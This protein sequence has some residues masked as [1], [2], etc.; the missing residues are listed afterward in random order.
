MKHNFS[1]KLILAS[2]L[3]LLSIHFLDASYAWVV[4]IPW[5]TKIS[6][7]SIKANTNG[8]FIGSI[9]TIWFR[10]LKTVKTI[11]EWVLILYIVYIWVQMIISMGDVK[12]LWNTKKQIRYTLV[13]LLFINIPGSIYS[14]FNKNG[15]NVWSID[16]KIFNGWFVSSTWDNNI[17]IDFFDFWYTLSNNVIAFLKVLIFWVA[18][19]MFILAW[20]NVITAR[21]REE[22]VS[23][24]KSKI[25]Y[26][27]LALLFLWIIEAWKNIA[28]GWS[29][30]EGANLFGTLAK[31]ALFFAG[32]VAIFFL[33]LA[34][35]YFITANGNEDTIKKAKSIVT[36][37]VLAT[38]I[39]LASYTFLLDLGSL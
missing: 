39:L 38:L 7:V 29:V 27:I 21:G 14:A 35:Y 26:S 25:I 23:E 33:S 36:N 19:F 17:F 16:G 28:F 37:T 6:E 12:E 34:G 3:L 31:L 18:L 9:N 20:I 32:P 10:L 1:L 13:A 2:I 15:A 24:A 5:A 11:L 4:E 8:D 22:K 30:T